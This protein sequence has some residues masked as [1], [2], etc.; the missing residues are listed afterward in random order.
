MIDANSLLNGLKQLKSNLDL[1]HK[2][3]VA[4]GLD[5]T[6]PYTKNT[7]DALKLAFANECLRGL[8]FEEGNKEI[9]I[10]S[11]ERAYQLLKHEGP[12]ALYKLFIEAAK[13][14]SGVEDES[15]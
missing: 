4:K 8:K 15:K 2:L 12:G 11:E 13:K 9:G 6:D 10:I 3:H 14:A 7:E 5:T 1:L